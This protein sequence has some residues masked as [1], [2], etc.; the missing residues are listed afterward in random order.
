M[1]NKQ[2]DRSFVKDVEI[3]AVSS[4]LNHSLFSHIFI[5]KCVA[6]SPFPNNPI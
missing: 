1:L 4:L 2:M 5:C 6:L 3:Y